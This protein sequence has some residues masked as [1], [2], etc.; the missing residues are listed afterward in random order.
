MS[1]LDP[2]VAKES[3][4]EGTFLTFVRPCLAEFVGTTL[5]VFIGCMVVQTGDIVS[6]G[7]A[8]GLMIA[9]LIMAFGN[10]R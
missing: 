10:I 5:F 3:H 9:L 6:I 1:E 7:L 4:R 2:L 8:H